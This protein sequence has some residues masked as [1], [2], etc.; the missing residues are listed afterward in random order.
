[1][2]ATIWVISQS[3]INFTK[4]KNPDAGEIDFSSCLADFGHTDH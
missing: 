2:I 1:M 3:I 4:N